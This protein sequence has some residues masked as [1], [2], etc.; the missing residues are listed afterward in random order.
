[1][2]TS[3]PDDPNADGVNGA[4]HTGTSGQ[5]RKQA[6]SWRSEGVVF[7]FGIAVSEF[8]G[9]WVELKSSSLISLHWK[10]TSFYSARP[11]PPT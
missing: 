10:R 5:T 1:M 8:E 7:C 11:L 2:Y 3:F 9:F 4:G 6:G